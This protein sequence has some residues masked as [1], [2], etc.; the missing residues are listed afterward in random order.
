LNLKEDTEFYQQL[1]AAESWNKTL[2][3]EIKYPTYHS[4]E[5]WHSK[6]INTQQITEL[7]TSPGLTLDLGSLSIQEESSTQAQIQVP[8][9]H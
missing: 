3:E 5:V 8:P 6:P 4:L 7:L 9:K 2:P 1:Q